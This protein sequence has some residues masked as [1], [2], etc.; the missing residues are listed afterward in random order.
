[1]VPF[2]RFNLAET[3]SARPPRGGAQAQ[4]KPNS[5]KAPAVEAELKKTQRS[6]SDKKSSVLET[7]TTKTNSAESSH[8]P[9]SSS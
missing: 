2:L 3:T 4:Q 1:M 7:G 9:V 8:S 6:R 5:A